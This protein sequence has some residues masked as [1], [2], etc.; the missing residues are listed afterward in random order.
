MISGDWWSCDYDKYTNTTT[1]AKK[2]LEL[3]ETLEKLEKRISK[4]EEEESHIDV[5]DRRDALGDR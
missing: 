4:L 3:D 5:C 1:A 2:I